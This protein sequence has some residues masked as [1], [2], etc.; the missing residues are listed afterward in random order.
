[1][2][3]FEYIKNKWENAKKTVKIKEDKKK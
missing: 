2:N 3:K 1:M